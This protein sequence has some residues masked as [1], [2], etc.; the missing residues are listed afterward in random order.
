MLS[1]RP[2]TLIETG[3]RHRSPCSSWWWRLLVRAALDGTMKSRSSSRLKKRQ[4]NPIL[5]GSSENVPG[6]GSALLSGPAP[7]GWH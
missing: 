2:W 1:P 5:H 7:Q 3:K 6:G 4:G